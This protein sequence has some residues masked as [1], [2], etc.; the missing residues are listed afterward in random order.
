M[1][2]RMIVVAL[3]IAFASGC[4]LNPKRY[5]VETSAVDAAGAFQLIPRDEFEDIDLVR[6]LDPSGTAQAE[7][8]KDASRGKWDKLS[9]GQKIDAALLRYY[10]NHATK[11]EQRTWR[12]RIQERILAASTQRCNAFKANLQRQF[13]RNNFLLGLGA[14]ISGVIGAVVPG[15]QASKYLAGAAGIFSGARAEWNQDFLANIAVNVIIDGIEQRQQ[16]VYKQIVIAGQNKDIS[17]YNVEAAIKDALFYHGQCSIMTGLRVASDAIKF[18]NDPGID[19]ATRILLKLNNAKK[20]SNGATDVDFQLSSKIDALALTQ[21]LFAGTPRGGGTDPGSLLRVM[22]STKQ[23][24]TNSAEAVRVALEKLEGGIN[25]DAQ[26]AISSKSGALQISISGCDR[27]A[28]KL[29]NEIA[30]TQAKLEN[31]I[32]DADKITLAG[33]LEKKNKFSTEIARAVD[34]IQADFSNL[35][36]SLRAQIESQ[37]IKADE[38]K[39]RI[40]A[41]TTATPNVCSL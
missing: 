34:L 13:S 39:K 24:V 38:A 22:F 8:D 16:E 19:A 17:A 35:A 27:A 29:T 32:N 23:R 5:S 2:T 37:K 15:V 4:G 1:N 40:E 36:D 20:V 31:S 30:E 6:L 28:S 25:T 21:Q 11:D 3:V 41:L 7:A 9:P 18:T 26:N 12:D 33:E 10:L 14:T